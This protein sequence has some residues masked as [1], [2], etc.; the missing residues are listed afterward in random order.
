MEN[1]SRSHCHNFIRSM[2]KYSHVFLNAVVRQHSLNIRMALIDRQS[3]KA[4]A[5]I[6]WNCTRLIKCISCD[7]PVRTFSEHK[8]LSPVFMKIDLVIDCGKSLAGIM[9]WKCH[10]L[11]S[12]A[13]GWSALHV[14]Y[15]IQNWLSAEAE[16]A[17]LT[18]GLDVV[19][20]LI[21]QWC[22]GWV[23]RQSDALC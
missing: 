13:N 23:L 5:K 3:K 16:A 21:Y 22:S 17:V 6:T 19:M 1:S 2:K 9:I 14:P 7:I 20:V 4:D 15:K 8:R 12:L 11:T 18:L 10:V